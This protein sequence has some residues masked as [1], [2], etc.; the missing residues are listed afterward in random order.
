MLAC[1]VGAPALQ[2]IRSRVKS[3]N[4]PSGAVYLRSWKTDLRAVIL[5]RQVPGRNIW[6]GS[7]PSAGTMCLVTAF[8]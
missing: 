2:A 4:S 5:F 3:I 7:P 1:Q 8:W 6:S